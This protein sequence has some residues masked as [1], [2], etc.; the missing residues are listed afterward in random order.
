MITTEAGNELQCNIMI[1][2]LDNIAPELFCPDDMVVNCDTLDLYK[3]KFMW[4]DNC[5]LDTIPGTDDQLE[6]VF[7]DDMTSLTTTFTVTDDDGNISTCSVTVDLEGDCDCDDPALLECTLQ[8]IEDLDC[9]GEFVNIFDL[10]IIDDECC[11]LPVDSL[12]FTNGAGDELEG[13]NQFIPSGIDTI[14]VTGTDGCGNDVSCDFTIVVIDSL[15]IRCNKVIIEVDPITCDVTLNVDAFGAAESACEGTLNFPLINISYDPNMIVS[16][17]TWGFPQG[18][19]QNQ[20]IFFDIYFETIIGQFTCEAIVFLTAG[21][22]NPCDMS[23]AEGITVG[24]QIYNELGEFI[25]GA[26]VDLIGSDEN[27][28]ETNQFGFYAFPQMPVGGAYEIMPNKDDIALNGVSTIDLIKIQR[29]ILGN[30]SLESA[31]KLIAADINRSDNVTSIDII[32]LRKLILGI[33]TEFPQNT[34]WRMVDADHVFADQND[35]FIYPIPETYSI[36]YLSD[37]MFVDFIGV[38]VGDVTNNA[39]LNFNGNLIDTRSANEVDVE[40]NT[41]ALGTMNSASITV[42]ETNDFLGLQM[43]F[44]FDENTISVQEVE[45]DESLLPYFGYHVNKG[46]LNMSLALGA[47]LDPSM[48]TDLIKINYV[49]EAARP[50]E[51]SNVAMVAEL[52]EMTDTKSIGLE[53]RDDEQLNTFTVSQN[54]PNPWTNQTN[55]NVYMPETGIV[56]LE[57]YNT[58][59]QLVLSKSVALESGN[60]VLSI[61]SNELNGSGVYHYKLSTGKSSVT[62]RFLLIE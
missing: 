54:H 1:E 20:D 29:H 30:E 22:N 23:G 49:G 28:I 17:M 32:E 55:V 43:S 51:L 4:S 15:T 18:D 46:T 5:S 36:N 9:D 14:F 7:N 3:A 8:Q 57:I 35:P 47:E 13:F 60:Q 56:D 53:Y 44:V 12:T 21:E 2:A 24:G 27:T 40:I 10:L 39:S 61:N 45:V 34:S 16:E 52:Y 62:K 19:P 11:P 31:Y 37:D 26:K 33:Y 25:P 58:N 38:K 41:E 59:G 50:F 48:L 42:P 6:C